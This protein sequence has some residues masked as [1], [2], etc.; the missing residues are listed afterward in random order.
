MIKPFDTRTLVGRERSRSLLPGVYLKRALSFCSLSSLIFLSAIGACAQMAHDQPELVA[1]EHGVSGIEAFVKAGGKFTGKKNERGQTAAMLAAAS[2]PEVIEAFHEAGG[3]FT[4]DQDEDGKT[5][6]FYLLQLKA[7]PGPGAVRY[8]LERA[9]AVESFVKAGGR[10]T[11]ISDKKGL[12]PSTLVMDDPVAIC[13]YR[14]G[15][16][17]DADWRVGL[18]NRRELMAIVGGTAGIR[19][20]VESGGVFT[21]L[22]DGAG[23]TAGD[24]ATSKGGEV[25]AAYNEAVKREGGLE[26][27]TSDDEYTA[28][29]SAQR[30]EA[31]VKAGCQFDDRPNTNGLRAEEMAILGGPKVVEAF[32]L[33]GGRFTNRLNSAGHSA[34]DLAAQY[35]PGDPGVLKAYRAAV[36]RQGGLASI[37]AIDEYQAIRMGPLGIEDFVKRGGRFDDAPNAEDLTP[38][39]VAASAEPET[40]EAFAKAGGKFTDWQNKLGYTAAMAAAY[41]GADAIRAFARAGGVFTNKQNHQGNT[42]GMIVAARQDDSFPDGK[43]ELRFAD[44]AMREGA[45]NPGGAAIDAFYAGGG[46]FSDQQNW[47]GRTAAMYAAQNGPEAIK[48]FARAGGHF[49][50]QEDK[51]GF[52]AEIYAVFSGPETIR[53]FAAAGGRFSDHVTSKGK[54]SELAVAEGSADQITA[55]SE[56]GGIFTDRKTEGM[57]SAM[58]ASSAGAGE[59]QA[60]AAFGSDAETA[61]LFAKRKEQLVARDVE[62]ER[63]YQEALKRQ[64]GLRHIQ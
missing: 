64:G 17:P 29:R 21:S 39:M 55:F 31:F 6:A 38:A 41:Y 58:L 14:K 33:H 59:I 2:S 50:D 43:I 23:K 45:V 4:D 19:A 22:T 25:L 53:A 52:T 44:K 32:S 56:S 8:H 15:L 36:K 49:T 54:S 3:V 48:A 47:Y 9:K 40:I 37:A 62:A 1:V 24:W 16:P 20:Y 42:V 18:G 27:V 61:S 7:H 10:F 26:H 57:T 63:A 28:L 12:T 51:A 46:R 35:D 30:V 5:A 13:A 60:L 34:A 11:E